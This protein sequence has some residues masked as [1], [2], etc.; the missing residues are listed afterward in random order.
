VKLVV[1]WRIKKFLS[2]ALPIALLLATLASPGTAYAVSTNFYVDGATGNDGNA[3]TSDSPLKTIQAAINMAAPSGDIVVVSAGTYPENL[4]INKTVTLECSNKGISAGWLPGSRLSPTLITGEMDISTA[5]VVIDGCDFRRKAS[6]YDSS[7]RASATKLVE[8]VSVTGEIVIRNSVFD[9]GVKPTGELLFLTGCGAGIYGTAAWRVHNSLFQSQTYSSSCGAALYDSRT[10]WAE[11]AAPVVIENNRFLN[12]SQSIYLTGVQPS[13]SLIENNIFEGLGTAGPFIGVPTGVVVRGNTFEGYGGV[14]LDSS[15]GT[16]IENNTFSVS[17]WFALVADKSHTG[18]IVRNNSILGQYPSG[19]T[20]FSGMTLFNNGPNAIDARRN[21]WG[22]AVPS[23]KIKTNP[24]AIDTSLNLQLDSFEL[25]Q[26]KSGYFGFWPVVNKG[27]TQIVGTSGT[28]IT[29]DVSNLAD[30]VGNPSIIFTPVNSGTVNLSIERIS[31][32]EASAYQ[33]SSGSPFSTSSI[34]FAL[35][36]D[37]DAALLP[38]GL[39]LC[40]DG[41]SPQRLWHYTNSEWVDVTS[42]TLSVGGRICGVVS[43]FSPFVLAPL[44]SPPPRP[45]FPQDKSGTLGKAVSWL[46]PTSIKAGKTLEA[47]LI[48]R[49]A[50]NLPVNGGTSGSAISFQYEGPG[51]VINSLSSVN[52][53]GPDGQY[54]VRVQIPSGETGIARFTFRY[55]TSGNLQGSDVI[56]QRARVFVG[57]IAIA[58]AGANKGNIRVKAF[59]AKGKTVNVYVSDQKVASFVSSRA[60]FVRVVSGI[61]AG[62]KNVRVTLSGAGQDFDSSLLIR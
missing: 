48:L 13:G 53:L 34:A 42:D 9:L 12:T 17:N 26:L 21:Y 24:G 16:I 30:N 46:S 60:N 62:T 41:T 45:A 49:D 10:I 20:G 51:S 23:T 52:E 38:P 44:R 35:L 3:G 6:D 32:A 28:S 61:Q 54:R 43:S 25:N 7:N 14:Y 15:K 19:Y 56:S 50:N 36:F 57:P 1:R 2:L 11:N 33:G 37:L 8:S 39:T 4:I 5:G 55:S 31:A 40:V 27:T 47:T 29:L 22:E 58:T 59:R 18:T